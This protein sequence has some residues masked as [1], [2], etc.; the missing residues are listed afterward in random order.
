MAAA[1][2]WPAASILATYA[3]A[4]RTA[5]RASSI[6]S[7]SRLRFSTR[8]SFSMLGQAH[9]SPIVRGATAW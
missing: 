7:A 8:A 6:S 1:V 2:P 4:A 9:S 5:A 3:S